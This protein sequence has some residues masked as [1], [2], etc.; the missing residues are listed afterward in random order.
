VI[1]VLAVLLIIAVAV[2][3]GLERRRNAAR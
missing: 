2:L 3:F 1:G